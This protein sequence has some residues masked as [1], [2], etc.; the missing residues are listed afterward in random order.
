MKNEMYTVTHNLL[1]SVLGHNHRSNIISCNSNIA[2]EL[3]VDIVD[4]NTDLHVCLIDDNI[5]NLF[6]IINELNKPETRKIDVFILDNYKNIDRV[7]RLYETIQSR[8]ETVIMI[9]NESAPYTNSFIN[10][11]HNSDLVVTLSDNINIIKNRLS[12]V[13][14]AS[15]VYSN[16]IIKNA[17]SALVTHYDTKSGVINAE[18]IDD[19]FVV[20]NANIVTD[21]T[22]DLLK[23]NNGISIKLF[24]SI[25]IDQSVSDLLNYTMKGVNTI[26]IEK[27]NP[28]TLQDYDSSEYDITIIDCNEVTLTKQDLTNVLV[29]HDT[30]IANNQTTLMILNY[31]ENDDNNKLLKSSLSYIK[32]IMTVEP[33]D[34]SYKLI[35]VDNSQSLFI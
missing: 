3:F 7:T 21:V 18:R 11:I 13:M 31:P 34:E 27:I 35:S 33:N 16:G 30:L 24:S 25:A 10:T 6:G 2:H 17:G 5:D 23:Q 22:I 20:N 12:T 15:D 9:M 28:L 19:G 32:N 14:Y 8:H 29:L 1:K 26:D 4:N